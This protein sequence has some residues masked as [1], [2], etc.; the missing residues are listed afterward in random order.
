MPK[1]MRISQALEG[2]KRGSPGQ[3]DVLSSTKLRVPCLSQLLQP[4]EEGKLGM[5]N[6]LYCWLSGHRTWVGKGFFHHKAGQMCPGPACQG[7]S[8]LSNCMSREMAMPILD[9]LNSLVLAYWL[10]P[11]EKGSGCHWTGQGEREVDRMWGVGERRRERRKLI[12]STYFE[13][14]SD[15]LI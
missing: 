8:P 14:M 13:G 9:S 4:T 1:E 5:T 12:L 10:L 15:G 6:S 2:W 11:R 3:T 7:H